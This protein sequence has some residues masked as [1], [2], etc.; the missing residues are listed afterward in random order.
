MSDWNWL[1]DKWY[2]VKDSWKRNSVFV[3]RIFFWK[4]VFEF[5]IGIESSA[6]GCFSLFVFSNFECFL[7]FGFCLDILI[8]N[9]KFEY[10]D[11]RVFFSCISDLEKHIFIHS[12]SSWNSSFDFEFQTSYEK[13]EFLKFRIFNF[14]NYLKKIYVYR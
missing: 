11:F 3:I 4:S 7:Q 1:S 9:M 5:N 10:F 8:R 13:F 6:K 12:W 2:Q 14:G